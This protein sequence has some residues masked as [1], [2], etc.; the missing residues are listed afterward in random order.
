MKRILIL[1]AGLVAGPII[2]HLLSKNYQLTLASNTPE[3]AIQI[4]QGHPNA[5]VV[6]WS[7]DNEAALSKMVSEADLAVSLLPYVFHLK[8]AEQCLV[9]GKHLVTTSYVKPEMQALHERAIAKDLLFL[10]EIGLDPGIDHMS[11][12]RVIDH[13]HKKG[14]KVKEFYSLCGALPAKESAN[15]PL[16]YKFSW[17]PRGVLLAGNNSARYLKHGAEVVVPTQNLFKDPFVVDFKG[18]GNMDVYPNR[19][20]IEYIDIYGIPE[21]E[22]VFRGTFRFKGWCESLDAMKKLHLLDPTEYHTQGATYSGF[23]SRI[24]KLD[25]KD[26]RHN[27]ATFLDVTEDFVA[28]EALEWLGWLSEL[29]ITE[30][31]T[32]AFD[33]TATMMLSK[34]NL[35]ENDRDMVALQHSFLAV[36]PDGKQEVIRSRMLA[37]GS[38]GTDTA[39]ARTVSLPAAIAVEM[40]LEGKIPV[41]GVYRP[42]VAGIY[43][44]VLD[45]LEKLG[46]KMEEEYD[47]PYDQHIR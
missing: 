45:A 43:E 32:S 16:K 36:Y 26:L 19:D 17:S 4:V 8:V 47:L 20:S 7:I 25:N 13:I 11:A 38:P 24:N 22:T 14:G 33:L 29:K 9:H 28:I 42:V 46:I 3:H 15:N 31:V 35:E 18:V 41:R 34:M 6:D 37:Y 10:N 12:M 2:R 44:P 23:L 40:I 30:P 1:G 27:I 21:A 5:T 39:I